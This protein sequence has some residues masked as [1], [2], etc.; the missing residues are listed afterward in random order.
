MRQYTFLDR[1]VSGVDTALRAVCIPNDR[2]CNRPNP[3]EK[4]SEGSLSK[5]EKRHVTGLMRINHAGEVCAQALYQG[6][7]ATAK[8]EKVKIQ[9]QNS[10]DEEIDHLAWCEKRI[11]ELNGNTSIL[12]PFWYLG[13]FII[14]AT[15]G[16]AGDKLSLGFVAE[17]EKQ[18]VSHIQKHIKKIPP[19]DLKTKAILEQ[20]E[21][22][23]AQHAQIAIDA[24]AMKLPFP[25]KQIM[26]LT[27]K[28]LTFT[29]YHI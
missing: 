4:I 28:L 19:E 20:M 5:Q 10:A 26:S 22:D 17:T 21:I 11:K 14:G 8:L 7:A 23:E 27:S 25:I 1:L 3:S 9:M 24:G 18:V 2:P 16:L 13:S 6:Q 15:A 12:N 29:S